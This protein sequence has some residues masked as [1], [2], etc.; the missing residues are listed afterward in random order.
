MTDQNSNSI[1]ESKLFDLA[2]LLAF[3]I[4]ALGLDAAWEALSVQ[5]REAIAQT[6]IERCKR[7]NAKP[8]NLQ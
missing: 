2:S 7:G 1:D 4:V 3:S 5:A 8:N 6:L